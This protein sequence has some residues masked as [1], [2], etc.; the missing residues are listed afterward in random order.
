M[1]RV[2]RLVDHDGRVVHGV[3]AIVRVGSCPTVGAT[4]RWLSV[5]VGNAAALK[6]PHPQAATNSQ[7]KLYLGS[8][9]MTIIPA[10]MGRKEG[11][12]SVL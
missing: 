11:R 9:K 12:L 6:K 2:R 4:P 7:K 8:M 1:I 10:E 3:V 5:R